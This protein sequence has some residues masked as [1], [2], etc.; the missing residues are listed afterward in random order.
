MTEEINQQQQQWEIT[1]TRSTFLFVR[2]YYTY[3]MSLRKG[4]YQ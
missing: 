3:A 1:L 2:R 4:S